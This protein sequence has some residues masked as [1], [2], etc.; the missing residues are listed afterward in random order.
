MARKNQLAQFNTF[1]GG[2]VTEAG[3]LTFP[4]N[5]SIDEVNFELL[6]TGSRKRRLGFDLEDNYVTQS[7][8]AT[9]SDTGDLAINW[10]LWKNV[11]GEAGRDILVFQVGQ[12]L[13]F[14]DTGAVPLSSGLIDTVT[15]RPNFVGPALANNIPVSFA[16]IDGYLVCVGSRDY[17]GI[18]IFSVSETTGL[19]TRTSSELKIRDFFGI[20]ANSY[21]N[22]ENASQRPTTEVPKHIYNLRNQGWAIPRLRSDYENPPVD[23]IS[24]FVERSGGKYPSNSDTP[25]QSLY[26]NVDI[27][28]DRVSK[29]FFVEDLI[30]NPIGGNTE[31]P[32][33]YF[34]INALSRGSSRSEEYRRLHSYTQ[35]TELDYV[36]VDFPSDR[37]S[38]S[39]TC[40]TAYAG[41]V[42]YAGFSG[43]VIDG[44]SRSPNLSSYVLFSKLIKSKSDIGKCFQEGD[45][46][47]EEYPELVDTDGGYIKLNE[48]YGIVKMVN[49]GKSLIVLA[50]NGVWSISGGS[51]FGFSATNFIVNKVSEHGCISP[52][53][54]VVVDGTLMY[55][56]DDGI[57]HIRPNQMGDTEAVN[58][59][60]EKIQSLYNDIDPDTK[61]HAAGIYDSYDKKVRWLYDNRPTST[62]RAKELI[63]DM[64]LG[65]FY[66]LEIRNAFGV[67][68]RVCIPFEVPPYRTTS[69][70]SDV[71]YGAD[72]VM[73]GA[74]E[75]FVESP[76]RSQGFREVMY[77]TL[78]NYDTDGT[79]R[80]SFGAYRD[81][82]FYDWANSTAYPMDAEAYLYTGYMSG[83]EFM[84]NKQAPY[85]NFYFERT[86]DGFQTVDG[87][88]VPTNQSSCKV[89][90]MWE[91]SDNI[92]S[93]RWGQEFQAYRYTRH[94]IPA[95]S[96]SSYDYGQS[97]IVT[98]NKLR[99]K[100]RVLSLY[101]RS[102]EGKDCRLL[103][104]SMM[105]S[106]DGNV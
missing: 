51:D 39:A 15:L 79:A 22:A 103:G 82:T 54:V 85:I 29:R 84:L 12:N 94:Y 93:G 61:L 97:V 60:A 25:I 102:E 32:R 47:S 36:A 64:P 9:L 48:A 70:S 88:V 73:Y 6:R 5:S 34:I 31:T 17:G 89:R 10:H 14:Y 59:S 21:T 80:F 90:A 58:I 87:E 13:K 42:F 100:G 24:F 77:L 62:S 11:S 23:P 8:T 86:E 66:K 57:Y 67:N 101:I 104:W 26:P 74:D 91:W 63:L 106:V 33:G 96:S 56:S 27:S 20:E 81:P 69:V 99:G 72:L 71:Y 30:A 50:A 38:G 52:R 46:T 1:V 75:V 45:P 98:K 2:L 4:D 35:Y 68:H 92:N 40:A 19:V 53:S 44:D 41:R 7:T 37:T 49:I 16:D 78:M 105:V 28:S 55:W 18:D 65:A 76:V 3:P 43:E 83:G 95:T